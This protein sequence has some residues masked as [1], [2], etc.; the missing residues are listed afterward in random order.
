M[1][2]LLIIFLILISF[3]SY[4]QQAPGDSVSVRIYNS[5]RFYLKKYVIVIEGK[6][7]TFADVNKHQYSN[8]QK[9]PYLWTSENDIE[10]TTIRKRLMQYDDWEIVRMFSID[11]IGDD[12]LSTGQITIAI[13][14][15][16]KAN[17]ILVESVI[18]KK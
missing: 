7:Y 15:K 1:K 17:N 2:Q 13:T 6:K 9:L 12:K 14:T 16:R 18:V 3:K 10:V 5:G 4:S 11:H 8:Y